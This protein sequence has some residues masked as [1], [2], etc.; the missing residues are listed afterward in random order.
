MLES[1]I[2]GI[3]CMAI[4]NSGKKDFFKRIND[5]QASNNNTKTTILFKAEGN[6]DL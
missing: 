2:F 3:A 6:E 5:P 4:V 1:I